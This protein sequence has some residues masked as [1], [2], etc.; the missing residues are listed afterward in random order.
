[1]KSDGLSRGAVTLATFADMSNAYA[2]QINSR[3]FRTAMRGVTVK[4]SDKS[5]HIAQTDVDSRVITLNPERMLNGRMSIPQLTLQGY[6]VHEAGHAAHSK[7]WRTDAERLKSKDLT[8]DVL[9]TMALLDEIRV[10]RRVADGDEEYAIALRHSFEDLLS[11]LSE[12]L[13]GE[14][15]NNYDVARLWLLCYGR[16]SAGI[17]EKDDVEP[18]D[19][20]ARSM[21]GDDIVDVLAEIL[22]EASV[23]ADA[24]KSLK[25]AAIEWNEL[26]RST[27]PE[28]P[29]EGEGEGE[30][31]GQM[32]DGEGAGSCGC[33]RPKG[34]GEESE[35]SGSGKGEGEGDGE[36]QGAGAA[37]GADGEA[38]G[39]MGSDGADAMGGADDEA[40]DAT[41]TDASDM[42]DHQSHGYGN[43]VGNR[44]AG[45][46]DPDALKRAITESTERAK[47]SAMPDH[48]PLTNSRDMAAKVFNSAPVASYV[49]RTQPSADLL[50]RANRFS[51]E[52]ERIAMPQIT[53]R[54]TT[55]TAPP[56]RL[57]GREA[58]RRSA[59]RE[60]GILD[61][62]AEPWRQ[63]ERKRSAAKPV[64]IGIMTDVSGSMSA[65]ETVVA[66]FT[67]TVGHAGVRIGA[68]TAAVTFGARI[69][70]T[71]S[72]GETPTE[73]RIVPAAD[74]HELFDEGA[75]ALDGVLNLSMK[76]DQ[77]KLLFI[78]GDGHW[79]KE[80]QP[81]K[82]IKRINQWTKAGTQVIWV[83]HSGYHTPRDSMPGVIWVDYTSGPGFFTKMAKQITDAMRPEVR[84]IAR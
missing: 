72:P 25:R 28:Q 73:V 24:F 18:M 42:V 20:V 40:G 78:F 12:S 41:E 55:S 19:L 65:Y 34:E 14:A 9:N 27:M 59:E 4:R 81:E 15:L 70:R 16:Y 84:K 44:P 74:G 30:G 3:L 76:S 57:R 29:G 64:V 77:A 22:G 56:G 79:V 17:V 10:E 53:R 6:L 35:G 63:I 58:L 50:N 67:H 39:G 71:L 7:V 13:G 32:S 60:V 51:R 45:E 11:R 48:L 2:E 52:L 8:V 21:L 49:T 26:I 68:R 5:E 69:T 83:G 62:K 23:G 43:T 82:C 1:M 31:E 54:R 38:E 75:A 46:H 61:S 47:V 37:D 80:G 66:E 33:G 36:G